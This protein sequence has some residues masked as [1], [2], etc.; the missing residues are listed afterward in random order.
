MHFFKNSVSFIAVMCV[1]GA[2]YAA[3]APGRGRVGVVGVSGTAGTSRRLPSLINVMRPGTATTTTTTTTSTT[4]ELVDDQECVDT[5]R[6]CMKGSDACDANFEECTTVNLFHGHMGECFSHLYQCSDAAIVDL[7]G[8]GA[9]RNNL[10]DEVTDTTGTTTKNA[11][12]EIQYRFPTPSSILGM[13]IAGAAIRN[14]LS[15]EDCVKKYQRCLKKDTICGEDFELCT[16]ASEFARQA[17]MCDS[18][19]AR[20]PTD[21][22]K[23][24]FDL[25][26]KPVLSSL[27]DSDLKGIVKQWVEDGA[28]LAA[29]NAVNTCYKVIDSCFANACKKNPYHCVEGVS[30]TTLNAADWVGGTTATAGG[31]STGRDI[32]GSALVNM[33]TR[34]D[35]NQRVAMDG[36]TTSSDVRKFFRAA[37]Q[38]TV[39]GNKYCYMT[40]N[41]G[42]APGKK[43]LLDEY[44]QEEVFDN[45]YNARKSILSSKVQDAVSAFNKNAQD[46]CLDTFRSCAINSCGG[47]S[48]AAC[49]SSVFGNNGSMTGS[50]NYD[51]N[52]DAVKSGCSGIVNTDANCIYMAAVQG[53]DG[54]KDYS[55][56]T[57]GDENA[58]D[59]L[60]PNGSTSGTDAV[61]V[62]AL[63]A[64]LA[65]AYNSVE[66]EKM[67]K[68][69]RNTIITCARSMC[70]KD[71]Q[72]C[73]RNRSDISVA[74][75]S[76]GAD[77]FDKSMNKMGGVLDYTIIQG[78]C[79]NSVTNSDICAE[80]LAISKLN[81][82]NSG[83]FAQYYKEGSTLSSAWRNSAGG[84]TAKAA[85][86]IQARDDLGR[87]LCKCGETTNIDVC[88]SNAEGGVDG[89]EEPYMVA[90]SYQLDTAAQA[91]LFQE[92]LA[93]VEREAQAQYKAKLTKEQNI[94]LAQNG[95][96]SP[97]ATYVWA[98][99]VGS[100]K[101]LPSQYAKLGLQDKSIASND[102][103]DSFCRIKIDLR[104]DDRDLQTLL[105]GGTIKTQ[106]VRKTGF[107]GFDAGKKEGGK[108][109]KGTDNSIAYFAAGDTFTCGS[110]LSDATL[111][112][113]SQKVASDAR[114]AAGEGSQKERNTRLWSSLGVGLAGGIGSYFGMN[115]I[116]QKGGTLGGLLKKTSSSTAATKEQQDAGSDCVKNINEAKTEMA[117]LD[118]EN[119]GADTNWTS[120]ASKVSLAK[121][122]AKKAGVTSSYSFDK[123]GTKS[124]ATWA[125]DHDNVLTEWQT[126]LNGISDCKIKKTVTEG[127][128]TTTTEET[129]SACNTAK[130]Q[131]KIVVDWLKK[132]TPD[133]TKTAVAQNAA[134]TAVT[135]TKFT[136]LTTDFSGLVDTSE[137][138]KGKWRSNFESSLDSM[139][140]ECQ[141]VAD[142]EETP[143]D[144][145]ARFG[146]NIA[147]GV[148]GGVATS[149][150]A[151]GIVSSVQKAKYE[152]AENEAVKEWMD[153]IGSKIHCYVNGELI[154]DFGDVVTINIDA[155]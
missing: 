37:C 130:Q 39:G 97:N 79:M 113:M 122:N 140:A 135:Y 126:A 107:F 111:D 76:T 35:A 1:F 36:K 142:N 90:L 104:S 88:S 136:N 105:S 70:G 118:D 132:S 5:Y 25:D 20:C 123:P 66:I 47:G 108:E 71:Y 58:F 143:K 83:T 117:K 68:Q 119:P 23:S 120:F 32:A 72:N 41:E 144:R 102:L 146:K 56:V 3:V 128:S 22:Y 43:D 127:N 80:S 94:C 84:V 82:R 38:S 114:I 19:L 124:S 106:D 137:S 151:A 153:N 139:Q 91:T 141:A 15:T 24:L 75:Y 40:F 10:A 2:A 57:A 59:V 11:A 152:T 73:Y 8:T 27:T 30:Y 74:A 145:R 63:N 138:A 60:F 133:T 86:Q 61:V 149:A 46:K 51:H 7:F 65:A 48:G 14:K 44:Y 29:A 147:A 26:T 110:W 62:Q 150:L 55:S 85:D 100:R 81:L 99:L 109:L 54:F 148:V 6:K 17:T 67:K 95:G 129:D 16:N 52:Y 116:Q 53:E 87:T 125:S 34:E 50:I 9:T 115:A 96:T 93:D 112:L 78:L 155:D 131:A 45:A 49:Y 134:K 28:A 4:V 12:Q 42:K 98:K 101:Q 154:G 64:E 31:T 69:C 89:C 92:V 18:T 21:G 13:D 103:Y 121:A 33:P 77:K